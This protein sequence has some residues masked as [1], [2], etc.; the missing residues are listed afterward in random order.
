MKKT[1]LLYLLKQIPGDPEIVI[2]PV[3]DVINWCNDFSMRIGKV[4]DGSVAL[5]LEE[6]CTTPEEPNIVWVN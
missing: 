4:E 5:G 2:C 6:T 3:P 1:E